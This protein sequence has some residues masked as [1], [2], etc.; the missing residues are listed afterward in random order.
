MKKIATKSSALNEHKSQGDTIYMG[1][2]LK[3]ENIYILIL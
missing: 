1:G 3:K 2:V